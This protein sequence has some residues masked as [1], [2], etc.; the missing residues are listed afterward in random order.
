MKT[1]YVECFLPLLLGFEATF[2]A[3]YEF[4]TGGFGFGF[5]EVSIAS[6]SLEIVA[7]SSELLNQR[8]EC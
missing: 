6:F 5:L 8:L 7:L 3:L 1:Y 2:L 4:V